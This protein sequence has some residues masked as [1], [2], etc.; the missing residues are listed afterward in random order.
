MPSATCK[1]L[2]H[3][4]ERGTRDRALRTS[5]SYPEKPVVQPRG[6]GTRWFSPLEPYPFAARESIA[7]IS[8][9][10][11]GIA[12]TGAA[13]QT[14]LPL[15]KLR[16]T[17][18]CSDLHLVVGRSAKDTAGMLHIEGPARSIDNSTG[19]GTQDERWSLEGLPPL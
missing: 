19:C 15:Q 6:F 3:F 16:L 1:L 7:V 17:L 18:R 2:V 4:Q 5:T 12:T 14:N 13:V 8:R 9:S 10:D 11:S